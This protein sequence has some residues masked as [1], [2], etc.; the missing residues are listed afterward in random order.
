MMNGAAITSSAKK[1]SL[2]ASC[3][4]HDELSEFSIAANKVV[5]I[6]NMME[7][8]RKFKMENSNTGY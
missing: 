1:Y 2:T 3:T 6:R 8:M 4:Y 5:G 7:E